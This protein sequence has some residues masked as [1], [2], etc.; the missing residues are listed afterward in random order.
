L[1]ETKN[2]AEIRKKPI[3]RLETIINKYIDN[4]ESDS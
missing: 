3:L 2:Y 4:I 1:T